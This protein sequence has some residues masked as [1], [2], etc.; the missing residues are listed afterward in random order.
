[1]F[2]FL[3]VIFC[4]VSQILAGLCPL[5][6]ECDIKEGST[7]CI[8]G[9]REYIPQF[10]TPSIKQLKINC[11]KIKKIGGALNYYEKVKL[12]TYINYLHRDILLF[13]FMD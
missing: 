8:N 6:C 2:L 11:N 10:L 5:G 12:S 13:L 9:E 1:M 7:V 4:V 3:L